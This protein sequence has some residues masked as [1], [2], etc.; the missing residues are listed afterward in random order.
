MEGRSVG[1]NLKGTHPRTIS[2]RFCLI[3]FRGLRGEYLNVKVY[4][5]RRTPSAGKSSHGLWPVELK[6]KPYHPMKTPTKV[7]SNWPI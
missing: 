5:V 4:D 1:H 2:A 6:I 3:W 7:G